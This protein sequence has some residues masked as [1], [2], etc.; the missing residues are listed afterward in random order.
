MNR[1]NALQHSSFVK[2]AVFKVMMT[3]TGNCETQD[4][5]PGCIQAKSFKNFIIMKSGSSYINRY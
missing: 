4:I 2:A 3:N 5:I 1:L